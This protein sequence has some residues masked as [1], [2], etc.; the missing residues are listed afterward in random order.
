MNNQQQP[1]PRFRSPWNEVL[2]LAKTFRKTK[3]SALP[4]QTEFLDKP[5]PLEGKEWDE[6]LQVQQ[7]E[8]GDLELRLL[9]EPRPL[10]PSSNPSLK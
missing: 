5:S 3:R 10:N 7:M 4:P 8:P 9:V 2:N 1:N 6:I